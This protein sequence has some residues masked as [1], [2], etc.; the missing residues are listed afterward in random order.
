MCD[1]L[2]AILV[3]P[4]PAT[5]RVVRSQARE[6]AT[7]KCPR[8]RAENPERTQACFQC[9]AP[10]G[11]PYQAPEAD[12]SDPRR[13]PPADD[14][15]VATIIPYKNVPALIAYY[16]GLFSCFPVLGLPLAIAS[17]VLGVK[18]LKAVR[19]NPEAHGTV[20]AWVGLICGTIG[21][22]INGLIVM[23][24]VIALMAPRR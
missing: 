5:D 8:C 22:L 18:G 6:Q 15:T 2:S 10:L 9:G 24:I 7:M 20:H 3:T 4:A 21:L 11:H 16:F 1:L 19:R 14:D 17:L 13:P 23:G 12:L